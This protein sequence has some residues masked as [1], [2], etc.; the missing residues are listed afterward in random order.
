MRHSS[1]FYYYVWKPNTKEELFIFTT[2]TQK[3][4]MFCQFNN[5]P[6]KSHIKDIFL[7][8]TLEK[9]DKIIREF[10]GKE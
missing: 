6:T 2:A 3:K 5:C 10:I 1:M 7:H 9:Q 8:A 4:N